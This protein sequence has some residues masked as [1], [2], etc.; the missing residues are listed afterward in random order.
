[1][2]NYLI[3]LICMLVSGIALGQNQSNKLDEIKVTP[4]KFTGVEEFNKLETNENS[5]T[6]YLAAHFYYFEKNERRHEGTEVIQFNVT[7]E[8]NVANIKITNSVSPQIDR[9]MI[10]VIKT[11]NGMWK[12]GYN[13]GSPVAM[14]KEIV[15]KVRANNADG[16]TMDRDF[17]QI[18]QYYFAKGSKN[19]FVKGNIKRALRNYDEG[20]R[21]KPHDKS[22]CMLRGLCRYELGMIE[23]ARQDWQRLRELG[24][25]DLTTTLANYDLGKLKGFEEYT[26]MF[27][28]KE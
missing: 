8:G 15:I 7:P 24:G 3:I 2:K 9:E 26:A 19:F 22:L 25:L 12:P 23:G 17:T 10:R 18:A 11:T 20:I 16:L 4:P 14:T 21:Y 5:I 28:D 13:N 1:M 27:V 6:N